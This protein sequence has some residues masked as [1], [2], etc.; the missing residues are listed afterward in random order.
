ME[1]PNSGPGWI[2]VGDGEPIP[3]EHIVFRP[4]TYAVVD[5]KAVPVTVGTLAYLSEMVK[6]MTIRLDR[7]FAMEIFRTILMQCPF[8]LGSHQTASGLLFCQ[9]M[10]EAEDGLPR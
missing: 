8:C 10:H 6:E 5:L 7:K 3:I 4:V 2:K 9:A 1:I